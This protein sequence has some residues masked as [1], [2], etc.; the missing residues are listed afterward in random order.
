MALELV[1]NWECL[2][3]VYYDVLCAVVC[4]ASSRGVE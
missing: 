2:L 3:S 4:C 1:S